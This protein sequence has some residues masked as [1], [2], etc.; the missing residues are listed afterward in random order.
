MDNR[1]YYANK[2][3]YLY[4][5]YKKSIDDNVEDGFIAKR[6][7]MGLSGLENYKFNA[8]IHN[9]SLF[10]DVFLSQNMCIIISRDGADAGSL[11]NH[12]KDEFYQRVSK[13][14]YDK[15]KRHSCK[16]HMTDSRGVDTYLKRFRMVSS[17]NFFGVEQATD[18]GSISLKMYYNIDF[19]NIVDMMS[20]FKDLI[21]NEDCPIYVKTRFDNSADMVTCRLYDMKYF[22]K[23]Y[24]IINKYKIDYENK[25]L[26]PLDENGIGMSLDQKGS[27]TDFESKMLKEYFEEEKNVNLDTL[28]KFINNYDMNDLYKFT[29]T[30][31]FSDV[32]KNEFIE[33]TIKTQNHEKLDIN[34]EEKG[35]VKELKIDKII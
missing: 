7:Y 29:F 21:I 24:S 1:E 19:T 14:I 23:I 35:K 16:L 30:R 22:D 10:E 26:L 33:N 34:S 18:C 32:D 2:L 27:I 4:E 6:I 11:Y 31:L 9:K 20:E 3:A 28:E 12:K 15:E 8:D 13:E 17:K 5:I 25:P